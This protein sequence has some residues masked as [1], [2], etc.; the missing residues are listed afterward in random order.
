MIKI[1]TKKQIEIMQKGG[2][3]ASKTL[4]KVL[5]YAKPGIT[6]KDLDSIAETEILSLNGKPSFK[7]VNNYEYTTC[8]NVNDGIVHGIPNGYV[9]KKGDLVSI[10]LG[11]LYDGFHTDLSYTLEVDSNK[12]EKFL[13]IGKEA[14][15]AAINNCRVGKRLGDISNA[16][17]VI[18]ENSGFSVSKD[19]VGH[20]IGK[21][22]HEDPY[23]PCY[24]AK[25]SGMKLKNG[26]V[27]AIEIIYQKGGPKLVLADDDWTL[28]TADLSLSGLFEKTVAILNGG[29]ILITDFN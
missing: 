21:N 1:K 6:L 16:M 18:V 25:N 17:Q 3:I 5:S 9:L 28:S 10:D 11:V 2:K 24:G 13:S 23:V 29:P 12:E 8:I 4:S 26:M 7:T 14:L 15:D 19:L 22:L 27:F 20:G